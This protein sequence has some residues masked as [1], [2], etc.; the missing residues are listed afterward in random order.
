VLL[1]AALGVWPRTTNRLKPPGNRRISNRQGAKNAPRTPRRDK[2]FGVLGALAVHFSVDQRDRCSSDLE[3][4]EPPLGAR[5]KGGERGSRVERQRHGRGAY[6]RSDETSS[7]KKPKYQKRCYWAAVGLLARPL[8]LCDSRRIAIMP[9]LVRSPWRL[10][11]FWYGRMIKRM[12]D[13]AGTLAVPLSVRAASGIR[14]APILDALLVGYAGPA[15]SIEADPVAPT[16]SDSRVRRRVVVDTALS[17]PLATA[18]DCGAMP[19][20]AKPIAALAVVR[21]VAIRYI[22]GPRSE[23]PYPAHNRTILDDHLVERPE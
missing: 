19:A 21:A 2:N 20:V 9:T 10:P 14:M 12:K 16:A 18:L 4:R 3:E 23:R 6:R 17:V 7:G 13:T 22:L 11:R 8:P 1:R 15:A 5:W